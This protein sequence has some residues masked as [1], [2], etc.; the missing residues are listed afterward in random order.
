MVVQTQER[1]GRGRKLSRPW[2]RERREAVSKKNSKP[3]DDRRAASSDEEAAMF[4]REMADVRPLPGPRAPRVPAADPPAPGP[5]R[6]A[7][8]RASSPPPL[9][10]IECRADAWGYLAHD[11]GPALL[12]ELRAGQRRP[13]ASL[14]LHGMTVAAA[15]R[16]ISAFVVGA[17]QAGRRV[18]LVV[19]GRGHRSGPD[20]PVLGELVRSRLA[21]GELGARIL[22]FGQAPPPL[23]GSGA[24]VILL[25]KR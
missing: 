14:D 11:A 8:S 3:E 25:R 15:D 19:H 16:A 2:F 9:T 7:R 5:E 21:T 18:I 4:V 13:E 6:Q 10:E 1:H 24:T 17:Q 23:G 20:G 22:A 12:R